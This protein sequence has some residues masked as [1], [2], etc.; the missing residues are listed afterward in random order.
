CIWCSAPSARRTTTPSGCCS[1]MSTPRAGRATARPGAA[2]RRHPCRW[3]AASRPGACVMADDATSPRRLKRE[4]DVRA[5]LPYARHVTD[6]IVALDSGA[7]MLC[8]K[9]DGVSF[10]TADMRDLND[11]HVK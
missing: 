2:R 1:S 6:E 4:P 3:C 9:L 8:L 11:W 5:A 7:L 10:E